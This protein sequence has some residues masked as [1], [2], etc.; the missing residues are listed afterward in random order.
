VLSELAGIELNVI[1]SGML[2]RAIAMGDQLVMEVMRRASE[3]VGHACLTVRHLIDPEVIVL[4]GGVVEA[5]GDF[6]MPFVQK[7]VDADQ[8]TGARSGGHV[9]LSALGDDAVVLG[10]VA[11][12]Q[13]FV[14]RSPFKREFAATLKYPEIAPAGFGQVIVSRKT[15]C[16][17]IYISVN[18]KVKNQKR[19][20]PRQLD[21]N[22]YLID[23][24]DL[25]RVCKGGP[26]VLFVGTGESGKMALSE[27]A[28]RYLHQ[29]SIKCE[30]LTT[31]R[32]IEA[33]NHSTQ[34]KATLI[35][36]SC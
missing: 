13:K 18:G 11:L 12:A 6:M 20:T 2:R 32:A 23:R 27:E 16:R 29:R 36:V 26:E 30:V 8:L 25:K 14:G 15:Y 34:R 3:V 28:R 33:Y 22:V 31:P 7:I 4:G 24:E 1:R 10:A 35:H 9:L 21:G 5:C 19:T 17:D